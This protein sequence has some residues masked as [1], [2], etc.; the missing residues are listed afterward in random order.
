MG[1]VALPWTTSGAPL[2]MW[3]QILVKALPQ[4]RGR[5]VEL[6]SS[7]CW[8]LLSPRQRRLLSAKH[9]KDGDH[10]CSTVSSKGQSRLTER[11]EASRRGRPPRVSTVLAR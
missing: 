8:A 3:S 10:G 11:F 7:I 4:N 5:S 6:A 9:L 1:I 2:Q